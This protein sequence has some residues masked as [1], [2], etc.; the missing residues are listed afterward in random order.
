[1]ANRFHGQCIAVDTVGYTQESSEYETE[2]EEEEQ[3][4]QVIFKPVFVSK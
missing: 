3:R 4:P 1:M 2:S